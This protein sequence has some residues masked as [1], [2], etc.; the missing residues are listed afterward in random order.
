MNTTNYASAARAVKAFINL[1]TKTAFR[2]AVER[3]LLENDMP[4]HDEILNDMMVVMSTDNADN[5]DSVSSIEQVKMLIVETFGN[6]NIRFQ[7]LNSIKG[8]ENVTRAKKL[9]NILEQVVEII[10]FI[11]ILLKEHV[12]S[13]LQVLARTKDIEDYSTI[14]SICSCILIGIFI[15][16]ILVS[17]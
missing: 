1:P 12:K 3:I 2:S 13:E 9:N 15:G 17:F 16:L 14:I 11:H 5:A 8:A 10:V 7:N 4:S 6:H